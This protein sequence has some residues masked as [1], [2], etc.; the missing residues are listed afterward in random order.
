MV[1]TVPSFTR[2]IFIVL[3]RDPEMT[4][5]AK[6]E[7]QQAQTYCVSQLGLEENLIGMSRKTSDKLAS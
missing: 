4:I 6:R 3:S 7:K 5:E 1:R 2:H